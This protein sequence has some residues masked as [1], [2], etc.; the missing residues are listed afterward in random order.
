MT[1]LEANQSAP[2]PNQ[3]LPV[4]TLRRDRQRARDTLAFGRSVS[5]PKAFMIGAAVFC[6]LGALW[7]ILSATH[8]VSTLFLPAPGGVIARLGALTADGTL[9]TDAR[10][11]LYR[12]AV[13]FLLA[14]AMAVPVGT[15]AGSYGF[16]RAAIEPLMDFVRYMPVVAFVPL[17][18]LWAGTDDVQKFLIIWIG[19]F[20][21]QVL[22][23]MDVVKR[24]PV[25]FVSLGRTLGLPGRH[26]LM[27]IVLPF[28]LPGIWDALRISL[29]WAWTWLVLAELVAATSGLGYRIVVSQRY[30]QTDTIVGY[31][32]VLG[33]LGLIADQIMRALEKVFFPYQTR[34]R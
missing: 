16:W 30:L 27:R 17:T 31:I 10:V 19:T 15:I 33:V 7:W 2:A 21:Q 25:D 24:V 18:I 32:L 13:A 1:F 22:L 29:G 11:S 14:S 12:I 3:P 6:A 34:E 8:A 9:L 20:F 26:I 28:A 23:I 4:S 5:Q